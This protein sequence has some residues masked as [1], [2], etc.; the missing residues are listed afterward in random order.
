MSETVPEEAAQSIETYAAELI[1]LLAD[2]P[3]PLALVTADGRMLALSTPLRDLLGAPVETLL[4][5]PFESIFLDEE[6]LRLRTLLNRGTRAPLRAHLRQPGRVPVAVEIEAIP[7]P[8]D[9]DRRVT[10]NVYP[11]STLHRRE[12]LILEFNLLGSSLLSA[13]SADQVYQRAMQA[14]RPLGIGMLVT[15]LEPNGAALRIDYLSVGASIMELLRRATNLDIAQLRIA[16]TVPLLAQAL[17]HD[18]PIFS[19]NLIPLIDAMLPAPAAAICRNLLHLVSDPGCIL[20]PLQT[21]SPT[22]G[23]LIVWGHVLSLQDA[24][25]IGTFA[26]QVGAILAQ[27]KLRSRLETQVQQLNSLATTARAVTTL[28]SLDE[29][30]RVICVQAQ[31]LLAAD[32]A[33]VAAPIAGT[34][35]LRY[36]MSVGNEANA[37]LDM[38]IPFHSSVSGM[39]FLKGTGRLVDDIQAEAEIYAPVKARISARAVL[40]QP[41]KH[42]GRV[43]GVLLVGSLRVGCFDQADLDH[44]GRYAEYAAVAIANAQLHAA[45]QQSESDQQRQSRELSALLDLSQAVNHSL[46]LGTVLHEGLR[47]LQALDLATVATVLLINA[48]TNAFELHAARGVPADVLPAIQHSSLDTIAGDVLQAGQIHVL[49][50]IE[51]QHMLEQYGIREHF[52]QQISVYIPLIVNQKRMGI[53]GVSRPEEHPYAERDLWLLQ[54]LANNLAQATAKAQAHHALQATAAQNARL[55]RAAEEVR[56]YLNALIHTTPDLLVIIR[57]DMTIHL[58]NPERIDADLHYPELQEGRSFLDLI[59]ADRHA[60]VLV[61]WQKVLDGQPQSIEIA[62]NQADRRP[63]TILLSAAL[64]A[65]YGEV[66]VI[67]KDVTEQHYTEMQ[68]RQNEKLAALGQM[69]AGAAHELNN[70][71]A[72]ILGLAQ[73]QLLGDLAPDVRADIERIE[74][75]ALRARTIVQQLLMFARA[76][77]P[78]PQP[79][80]IAALVYAVIERLT[81]TIAHEQVLVTIEI[82]PKL[83]KAHGDPDQIEQ[84]L[85]NIMHNALQALSSNPP[86]AARSI[87]IQASQ[88]D[89]TIQLAITDSGPGIAPTHLSHIFEPFFTTRTIGQGTGLGLAIS[90]AIIQQHQGRISVASTA[91][92]TTFKV[93]LPG[94]EEP[95]GEPAPA[96]PLAPAQADTRI[97]LVEDEELVRMVILR[98]L[99]RHN[100]HVDAVDSGAAALEQA[101]TYDYAL[102]ISDLQMPH[103][104]GPTLY[105]NLRHTRPALRWLIITGDTM[106]ERSHTFLERTGLPALSKPFTREQLLARVAECLSTAYE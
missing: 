87:H 16:A 20:A 88:L 97:L 34:A 100:Y 67:V 35:A 90:H 78:D 101:L 48:D 59:P 38:D 53:L 8:N 70:P 12:R 46:D 25:F 75:S 31:E 58:L 98:T 55:Y 72:A 4:D 14:L 28:G 63:Y 33:R 5:R 11:L 24:P 9:P 74:R 79:V 47:V 68:A 49:S 7:I 23:V 84:V 66:F 10:V 39:V 73:L 21:G 60:D 27:L 89:D 76:E 36:I 32:F 22:Q 85:F 103:M 82:A 81:A 62:G 64:I 94:A 61:S 2:V 93:E 69:V 83:P 71:L 102:I 41:L 80:A 43:L 92:Q 17:T 13:Q 15:I 19:A 45:L 104:D 37:L 86:G 95:A 105:E 56:S 6:H 29:V 65:D 3:W 77:R 44:L 40:Y 30:L 54:A 96:A 57:P 18:Q 26:H 50:Q 51:R 42:Q 91:G 52:Q 106:G 1:G 99:T